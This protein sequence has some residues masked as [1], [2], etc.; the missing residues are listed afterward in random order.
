MLRERNGFKQHPV[1]YMEN[2]KHTFVTRLLLL[3]SVTCLT[4]VFQFCKQAII[5]PVWEVMRVD[6]TYFL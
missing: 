5:Y 2:I 6:G 4:K 1:Q 3:I